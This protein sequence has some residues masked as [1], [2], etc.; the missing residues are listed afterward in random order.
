MPQCRVCGQDVPGDLVAHLK[1]AHGDGPK[2]PLFEGLV[3]AVKGL[4][5]RSKS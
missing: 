1:E 3:Q 2:K 5:S 4:F